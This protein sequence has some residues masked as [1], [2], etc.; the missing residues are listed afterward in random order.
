MLSSSK[1]SLWILFPRRYKFMHRMC[2]SLFELTIDPQKML[3]YFESVNNI[4]NFKNNNK[5]KQCCTNHIHLRNY[6]CKLVFS[7]HDKMRSISV[8]SASHYW[9]VS[10]LFEK[11]KKTKQLYWYRTA[12]TFPPKA[13]ISSSNKNLFYVT[14]KRIQTFWESPL[15]YFRYLVFILDE[16]AVENLE[17]N[18]SCTSYHRYW[19]E[20]N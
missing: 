3:L 14:C 9:K 2:P 18:N 5:R 1:I 15:Q 19:A 6:F 13:N 17:C 8:T 7:L 10:F 4:N 11:S 16:G 12:K 20:I